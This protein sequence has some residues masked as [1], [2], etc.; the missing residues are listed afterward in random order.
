MQ[1]SKTMQDTLEKLRDNKELIRYP[2]GFWSWREVELKS[3]YNGR[4]FMCMVPIWYC[5]VKTLHAL[6]K[7]ELVELDEKNEICRLAN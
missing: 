5:D 2:G 1:L 3:S 6:Q 7:R 4:E